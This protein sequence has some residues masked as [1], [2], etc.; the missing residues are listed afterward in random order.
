MRYRNPIILAEDWQ[1]ALVDRNYASPAAL[2]RQLRVS[3]ARVSQVLRLIRL[4]PEVRKTIAALGDPL[5]TPVVTERRL[6]PTINLP[7]YEQLQKIQAMIAEG[8]QASI[9]RL[10]NAGGV[11]ESWR[12]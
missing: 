1:E 10:E 11:V 7:P 2:A 3:R 4:T 8:C 9:S 12:A 6:R 5:P